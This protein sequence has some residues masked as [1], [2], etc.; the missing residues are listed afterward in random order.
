MAQGIWPPAGLS[1]RTTSLLASLNEVPPSSFQ[2]IPLGFQTT[3]KTWLLLVSSTKKHTEIKSFE[4]AFPQLNYTLWNSI[5]AGSSWKKT[6][7]L[8]LNNQETARCLCPSGKVSVTVYRRPEE[9][10]RG[11]LQLLIPALPKP[12]WPPS[13]LSTPS[14]SDTPYPTDKTWDIINRWMFLKQWTLWIVFLP[15]PG[16]GP[17][18]WILPMGS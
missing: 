12:I 10:F 16:L 1:W 3:E 2:S 8:W 9:S 14:S 18:L 13:S 15:C 17:E 11:N 5:P 4:L 6:M 7:V